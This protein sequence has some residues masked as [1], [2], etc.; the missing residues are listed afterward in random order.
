MWPAACMLSGQAC[1]T[2]QTMSETRPSKHTS[3]INWSSL[4]F[5]IGYS[6]YSWK[7]DWRSIYW[8]WNLSSNFPNPSFLFIVRVQ[9]LDHL[10]WRNRWWSDRFSL[11][12]SFLHRRL[13]TCT[14]KSDHEGQAVILNCLLRNYLHYALYDQADKL[15]SK[16]QFPA[17]ASNNEWARYLYYLG[18]IKA[19]Q[20]EY[21][22]AQRNLL[23]AMRKAPQHTAVGFKQ[24]VSRMIQNWNL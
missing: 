12:Y 9:N 10:V 14:L 2:F 19:I 11:R 18:R 7:T 20:L 17:T 22:S 1:Q 3:W 6:N 21:S 23:Q 5:V 8:H 16:C 13:R 15:V 24:T 4:W